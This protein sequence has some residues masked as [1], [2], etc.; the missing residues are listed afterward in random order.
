MFDNTMKTE[1]IPERV[2]AL[3]QQ[4]LLSGPLKE[5]ELRT[6]FE[7]ECFSDKTAYFGMVRDAAIQL[8]LIT[9]IPD[10]NT[11]ELN[12]DK[13]EIKSYETMRM[14][15]NRNISRLSLS[16]FYR[17][18]KVSMINSY[19]L[20]NVD[21]DYQNVS[22]MPLTLNK[23]DENL[24]LDEGCMRAWRFWATFLGFGYLHDM[25]F[26]P[27]ASNFI[28]D[29]IRNSNISKNKEYPIYD[30]IQHLSP[31]IDICL[32]EKEKNERRLNFAVSNA[33]RAL[34]DR[35]I[36]KL[37]YTND[38]QDEW[39]MIEMPMHEFTSIIT[40]VVYLGEK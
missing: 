38:R 13:K 28:Y 31:S 26:M 40:D 29:C 10:D 7:P 8:G 1:A 20:F 27:N 23:M 21:K 34:H 14:Y 18:T 15:I 33:F 6:K 19:D 4:L 30:F 32:S 5:E 16:Q 22:K 36:I 3:C 11:L 25:F 12:V 37:K 2:F 17:T 24:N 9:N 35:G 39:N